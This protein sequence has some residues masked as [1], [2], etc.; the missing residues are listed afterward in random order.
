[1]DNI[2]FNANDHLSFKD[3]ANKKHGLRGHVQIYLDYLKNVQENNHR[4]QK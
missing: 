4:L 2:K 3:E 1:M